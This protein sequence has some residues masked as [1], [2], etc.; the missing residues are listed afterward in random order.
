MP[1]PWIHV[2]LHQPE[3]P[4]NTGNIG[5]TCVAAGAKLWLVRPLGFRM[6]AA[7]L[8]RA[9]MD[10]WDHLAWEVVDEWDALRTAFVPSRIWYFTKTAERLYTSVHFAVGD[11]LVFGSETGGLP[12]SLLRAQPEQAIRIPMREEARSLNLASSVAIGVYEALRQLAPLVPLW[13]TPHLR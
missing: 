3:I 10:Y 13:K 4:Q 1:E 8:R 5:R 9:G 11:A 2:V 6:D 12:P 7:R